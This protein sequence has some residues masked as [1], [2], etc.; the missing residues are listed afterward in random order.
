MKIEINKIHCCDCLSG[1]KKIGGGSI[2]SIICDPP[3]FLGM[4]HDGHAAQMADLSICLPFYREL[5]REFKRILA[6]DGCLY[7]FCDWRSYAFY[8][9]LFDEIKPRNLLV[10]DKRAGCGSFYTNEHELIVFATNNNALRLKGARNIIREIP[11]FSSGAKKTNGDKVHP[12]QKPVELI[13]KLI[14]DSTQPG[15]TVLDCFMGSGTTAIAA[16]RTG[17]N[18]YGFEQQQK[19][20][21]IANNRLKNE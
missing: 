13:E 9:Q 12:T 19:Y 3:Y 8:F 17:R 4:T 11:S 2:Q 10:W 6:P 5:F 1:I 14:L 15:D 18:F 20:V 16:R 7:W 21:D